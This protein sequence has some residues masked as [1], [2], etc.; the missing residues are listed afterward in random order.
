M[1]PGCFCALQRTAREN[2]VKEN[3]GE[4]AYVVGNI[5]Y[6]SILY[7]TERMEEGPLTLED[8]DGANIRFRTVFTI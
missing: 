5:M 1:H 7:F 8:Y 2:L 4:R 6:D 3:L